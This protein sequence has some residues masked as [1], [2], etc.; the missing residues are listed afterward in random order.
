MAKHWS[1]S[2]W[3]EKFVT[4]AMMMVV[5]V[6]MA[7]AGKLGLTRQ[8]LRLMTSQMQSPR[9][10]RRAFKGYQPTKHDV[11]VCTYSKSGTYWTMQ[12]AYQITRRGKGEFRHIHD[13]VPWPEAPMPSVVKLHDE[14]PVR[15]AP[16]GLRVIKTHLES[17]YVP[18]SPEA[19][20]IVV[21]RD[22]KDAFV[23]S[24][25]FSQG[26]ISGP[27]ISVEEWL[28]LFLF[29]KFQYGSWVEHLAGYWPWRS[30]DNVLF[31]TFEEMK[32]DHAGVVRRI[33]AFMGVALTD[34][35][36]AQVVEK[37]QFQ[38]M[39]RIDEKFA[40]ERP[41]PFSKRVKGFVMM[42]KGERGGSSE[43]LSPEQ[44]ALIDRQ[45]K[46]ELERHSCD[47]PYDQT[48]ETL[49]REAAASA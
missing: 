32:A 19:K 41:F 24:Y 16:T 33:A 30:R 20:Y 26:M 37:S 11:F 17:T 8:T 18:Y 15:A 46:A 49:D 4:L 5:F 3:V 2:D 42:R 44:Q 39:K 10:K 25:F 36:F 40:P 47:F 43:L 34:A 31:L 29:G 22:P 9:I 7:L 27:M 12:I 35:E 21:V 28:Q 38:Y 13:V 23:S 6:I 45:M 48:F 1:L 14:S